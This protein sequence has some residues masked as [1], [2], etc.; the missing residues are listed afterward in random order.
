[1]KKMIAMAA[2]AAAVFTAGAE[3]ARSEWQ[4]KVSTGLKMP[5]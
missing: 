3:M 4:G 5:L 2:L 1:M